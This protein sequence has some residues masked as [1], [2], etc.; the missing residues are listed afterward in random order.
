MSSARSLTA[1]QRQ[2][3]IAYLRGSQ[4][5]DRAIDQ[6]LRVDAE[7]AHPEFEILARLSEAPQRRLRMG[8]LAARNVAPKSRLTYQIDRL[9]ARGLVRRERH[10]TD[11]R[12][13]EAVLTDDGM[14]LLLQVAPGHLVAVREHL[15][16]VLTADELRSLGEIMAKVADATSRT[17]DR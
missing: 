1:A 7:L 4:L 11:N 10:A 17:P 16:D 13:V 3:W 8:A 5:L 9:V 6:Q 12:G 2:A 15:V 14:A